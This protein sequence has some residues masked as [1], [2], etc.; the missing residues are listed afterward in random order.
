MEAPARSVYGRLMTK[1]R[2]P[3]VNVQVI[4]FTLSEVCTLRKGCAS[5]SPSLFTHVAVMAFVSAVLGGLPVKALAAGWD[6][7]VP[8]SLSREAEPARK[9]P[10]AAIS[11]GTEARRSADEETATTAQGD[12]DERYAP[13]GGS[14]DEESLLDDA[15][16][17]IEAAREFWTGGDEK[18][19]VDTLDQAYA[20]ILGVDANDRSL[21]RQ[22]EEIRLTISKRLLEIYASRRT[23]ARGSHRAI[24]LTVNKYVE[25]EIG[26]FQGRER[27]FFLES[28][29]RSGIYR[30]DIVK[31]L[32]DAG[33][34]EELSWLPLIESG[35]KVRALSRSR[36]LGLWQFIPSTA[37]KYGLKRNRWID[38]RLDPVKSMNA[39]IEYLTDLHEIFGDWATVL[40]AYN[41]GEGTVLRAI[42]R[43]KKDY[44]DDFWDLYQRL[45]YETARYFPRFLAVLAI[46]KDPARYGFTLEEPDAPVQYEEV[47]VDGS[48]SL[49]AI[50]KKLGISRGDLAAL[51][52]E[53]RRNITPDAPYS[54][55]IPPGM[56]GLLLVGLDEQQ[57]RFASKRAYVYHRVAKGET[58][59]HIA[60]RYHASVKE[61]MQV[62]GIEHARNLRA[63]QKLKIPAD[64]VS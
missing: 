52:P 46:V 29:R 12:G 45:P 27:Q 16:D 14:M 41:C 26:L 3:Q 31:A 24:P 50:A 48:L 54:L 44:L 23:A 9:E 35:F 18:M 28:Y 64:A 62:N 36:A 17:L 4:D 47:A 20:L 58:L 59:S 7:N 51:N 32:K 60:L 22:K 56:S 39:A 19:S 8:A 34:P 49:G 21:A 10:R 38:E 33:L 43:Q 63:G 30:G 1:N 25:R 53:L 61:I 57:A 5:M 11:A 37:H 2:F 6:G 42:S 15:L 40:A 13:A 55:K